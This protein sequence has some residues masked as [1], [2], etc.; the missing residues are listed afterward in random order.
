MGGTA[1]VASTRL[2]SRME[3]TDKKGVVTTN[4]RLSLYGV[5]GS[6]T[7]WPYLLDKQN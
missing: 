2:K 5:L 4:S 6:E 1:A 3:T 7:P